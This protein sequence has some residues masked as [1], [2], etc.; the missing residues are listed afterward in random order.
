MEWEKR[1]SRPRWKFKVGGWRHFGDFP[2]SAL[3]SWGLARRPASGGA[4]ATLQGDFG[5]YSVFEQKLY[6][7][8]NDTDRG[9]GVF[10]RASYS[11]RIAISSISM[12]MRE[13]NSLA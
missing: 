1:R 2:T 12:P 5:L 10:A 13:S 8:G 4:P 11:P 9:I 7:V 6:R 3:S